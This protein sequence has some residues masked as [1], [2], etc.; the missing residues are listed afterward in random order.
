MEVTIDEIGQHLKIF[1]RH[2]L[3]FFVFPDG[4][5]IKNYLVVGAP[6]RIW[7]DVTKQ[8]LMITLTLGQYGIVTQK[9]GFDH[10]SPLLR[11][12]APLQEKKE[13]DQNQSCSLEIR[14]HEFIPPYGKILLSAGASCPP[15]SSPEM[16][17]MVSSKSK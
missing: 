6:V 1:R 2:I 12:R 5:G 4:Y 7:I 9:A 3:R 13:N 15:L 11:G 16:S 17:I 10:I 14:M 8:C